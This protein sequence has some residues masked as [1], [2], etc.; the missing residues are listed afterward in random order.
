M[1]PHRKRSFEARLSLLAFLSSAPMLILALGAMIYADCSIWPILLTALLGTLLIAFCC[2][3]IYQNTEYQFRSLGNLLDAMVQGDYSMRARSG[4]SEGALNELVHTINGLAARLSEQRLEAEES[5]LLVRT[6]IEHIEVAIVALSETGHLRFANPAAKKLL[7]IEHGQLS[8]QLRLQLNSV[9]QHS[10]GLHQVMELTLGDER[11]RFKIHVEFFRQAGEQNTL[12]F[13]T[14]VRTLLRQEEQL[15]W[16]RLVRVI[17]HEINNSLTPITSISQTLIKQMATPLADADLTEA[18][19]DTKKTELQHSLS[20][21]GERA[22]G[23]MRFVQ[24]YNQLAKL[25]EPSKKLTSVKSLIGKTVALFSNQHVEVV[26][27]QDIEIVIDPIQIEQVLINLIKNALEASHNSR[28]E[29]AWRQSNHL[30][31]I[32]VCD[33]GP[34]IRNPDN[35]FV[36]FYSTKKHGAGIG[37]ILCRE[38]IE[39]HAGHIELNNIHHNDHISGCCATLWL[40]FVTGADHPDQ[41]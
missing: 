1:H 18:E 10:P 14:D 38:I 29:I 7:Q 31:C 39:A 17:S 35:L 16:Q 3:R 36:P 15:A 30:L 21:I 11:G 41:K 22:S 34:G 9:R 32:T 26:S 23:L 33:E 8:E 2:Y 19:R 27:D 13:I 5:L 24:S 25:A 37:L 40:P 20:L 12:L 28:I 4:R 6:V